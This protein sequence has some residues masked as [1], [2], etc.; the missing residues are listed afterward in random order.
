VPGK[1]NKITFLGIQAS[2]FNWTY[3]RCDWWIIDKS[4]RVILHI[5]CQIL[6]TISGLCYANSAP[7]LIQY[8]Y[9]SSCSGFNIQLNVSPLRLAVYRQ[10]VAWYTPHLLSNT[11]HNIRFTLCQQWCQLDPIHLHFL[12]LSHQYSNE[13]TSPAISGSSTIHCVL[14]SILAAKYSLN[15]PDFAVSKLMPVKSNIIVVLA[16]HATIFNWT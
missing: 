9:I 11:G 5:C 2:I 6:A 1:P 16:I 15:P 13:R 4:M 7:V 12:I 14:Y 3:L 10:N 8:K